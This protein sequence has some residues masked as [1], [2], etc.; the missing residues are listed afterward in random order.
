M[1]AVSEESTGR[2]IKKE[3]VAKGIENLSSRENKIRTLLE[4]RR[5]PR[6]G[7]DEEVIEHIVRTLSSLDTNNFV[8]ES[9]GVGEREGRVYSKLVARR[10]YNLS[11]GIGRSGDIAEVQPKAAGSSLIYTLTNELT[12]HAL[13]VA[14]LTTMEKLIVLPLATGMSL[15]LCLR[16]LGAFNDQGRYVVFPRID[17]KSCF[18]SIITAGYKPLVVENSFDLPALV[19]ETR[20]AQPVGEMRSNLTEI[21]NLL[22][23]YGSAIIAV[24]STTSC[25][26]PRQPDSVVEIS[27]LCQVRTL[28]STP[29]DVCAS[30]NQSINQSTPSS[31]MTEIRGRSRHQQC[32]RVTVS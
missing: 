18:K 23:E 19:D 13:K 6:N 4:Q 14:G 11:H 24:L 1:F 32:I 28:F 30:I 26:A 7:F 8:E 31:Y 9:S 17:Q 10:H 16:T 2:L 3:Y 22:K 21:E 20:P 15:A 29:V 12:E 25:F 5:L 27:V